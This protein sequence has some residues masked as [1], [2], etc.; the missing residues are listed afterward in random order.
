MN[1]LA[2]TLLGLAGALLL[3]QCRG[4]EEAPAAPLATPP[5]AEP[6]AARPPAPT[7]TPTPAP[8]PAS[9]AA[10]PHAARAP[11]PAFVD[12]AGCGACH[13]EQ[14]RA[15]RGSDHDLAM[16]PATTE[17]VLG[18]FADARFQDDSTDTRFTRD[19]ERF[20][21]E[22][23]GPDGA[24]ASFEAPYV[25]GVDPLQQVLLQLPRGRLQAHSLAWDVAGKRWYSLYPDE[26]IDARD[27][28]HWTRGAMNW[29]FSCAECHA[30]DLARNYDAAT[31]SF[32]TT[33][34]RLDVGCQ[35]CHGPGGEH[36][37]WV[38]GRKSGTPPEGLGFGAHLKG[39]DSTVEVEAC[40]RCHARRAPLGDGF[41][42]RNRLLDDYLPALLTEGL[43]HA[44]G[45][46]LDEV[47]EYGSFLQSKMHARGVRCSDCHDPHSARLRAEGNLA[48]TGCHSPTPVARAHVDL[49]QLQRKQYDSR[50]HHHHEPG[51]P[52]SR[53]VDCHMSV[54][55]YMGVDPRRDHGFRVPRPDL[56]EATGAPDA[57]TACHAERGPAWAAERIAEWHGKQERPAH[58]GSALQAGRT[59]RAG[60]VEE[61]LA[62]LRTDEA[63][64]VRATAL[65]ELARYPS[66]QALAAFTAGLSDPDGLVRLGAT[67]G[68][69]LL[70]PAE[71]VP[72]LG[73][74]LTDPLR[75]LR[76]E[77]A[78]LLLEAPAEALG[79]FAAA[80]Q[81]AR[82]EH[83]A[84]QRALL[85]RPEAHLNLAHV[86][87]AAG[88]PAEA[89]AELRAALRLDPSFVPAYANL[90]EL[91]RSTK[92]EREAEGWLRDGLGAV[93]AAGALHHALGLALVRQGR[94]PEGLAALARAAEL[95]PEDP[96]FGYVHAVALDDLGQPEEARAVLGRV[97]ARHPWSRDARLALASYL[98]AAGDEAGARRTLEELAAINPYDPELPPDV[99]RPPP[100]R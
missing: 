14:A 82:A 93:P 63:P 60:A 40:A 59:G 67:T 77:A 100:R 94:K 2:R 88:R 4:D 28:L 47:Y 70:A 18:D 9:A 61:L 27:P 7:G 89:E 51:T 92:G 54:R 72:L 44:D 32:A 96:R 33:W 36:L 13:A 49:A 99:A 75:A 8:A 76:A 53:C 15:W 97:L 5:A 39:R 26:R 78:R 42:H 31:D 95:A 83:E 85:E 1:R 12:E 19:G 62:L 71:R 16:Q 6:A 58:F 79:P 48:C 87:V 25:F 35:A 24:R 86:H 81:A 56:A 20:L 73:P 21:V 29:N 98:A 3:A 37:E 41:D 22:T 68:T 34:H 10:P 91:A 66:A 55:T 80:V 65:V 74:L 17:T 90:A 57:C 45:Q 43:Y 64:I 69:E 50:E 23:E 84:I 52:G 46:I 38:L 30:T 11:R